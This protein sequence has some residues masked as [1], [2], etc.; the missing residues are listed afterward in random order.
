M[1]GFLKDNAAGVRKSKRTRK[2]VT[3]NDKLSMSSDSDSEEEVVMPTRKPRTRIFCISDD[4]SSSSSEE[5]DDFGKSSKPQISLQRGGK[6]RK[7]H[8]TTA[9]HL[10]LRSKMPWKSNA[11]P[12]NQEGSEVNLWEPPDYQNKKWFQGNCLK[13]QSCRTN[14]NSISKA[15]ECFNSHG[16]L[17]CFLCFNVIPNEE[18]ATEKLYQHYKLRHN[19]GNAGYEL[20]CPYCKLKVE[21]DM[22]SVHVITVHFP[23]VEVSLSSSTTEQDNRNRATAYQIASSWSSIQREFL[24]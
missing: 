16:E 11:S 21:F 19:F 15:Y 3:Y 22:V 8:P 12:Q 5:E 4:S 14:Y 9:M 2:P 13:C 24:E 6:R 7:T 20:A 18:N 17:R 23:E 10:D 1:S